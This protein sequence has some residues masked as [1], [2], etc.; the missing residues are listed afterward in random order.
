MGPSKPVGTHFQ[1][2]F[3]KAFLGPGDF[4]GYRQSLGAFKLVL[5][6]PEIS[7]KTNLKAVLGFGDYFSVSPKPKKAFKLV[8]MGPE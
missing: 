3:K 4:F 1:N 6:G 7:F 8:P 2:H 5:R